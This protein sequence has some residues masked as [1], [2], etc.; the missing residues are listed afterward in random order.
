MDTVFPLM[1]MI[2]MLLL[3][4]SIILWFWDLI[5]ILKSDFKGYD[6]IIWILVIIFFNVIGAI[7]YIFIGRNQKIN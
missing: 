6:K 3:V 4:F 5:D 1:L 7:L 2:M